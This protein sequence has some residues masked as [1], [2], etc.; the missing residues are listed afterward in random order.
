MKLT[1]A[2]LL[3]NLVFGVVNVMLGGSYVWVGAFNFCVVGA[4][5][6]VLSLGEE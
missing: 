2:I 4:L 1:L 3:A 5:T 6:M